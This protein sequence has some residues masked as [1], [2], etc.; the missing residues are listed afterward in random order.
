L[1]EQNSLQ[2]ALDG[3]GSFL[4]FVEVADRYGSTAAGNL[5]CFY[6]GVS[7]LH[8][9]QYE[10]AITYLKKYSGKGVFGQALALGNIGDAY[11]ELGNLDEALTYYKKAAKAS[12][13]SMTAPRFLAK[14]ALIL[15]QQSNYDEAIRLYEQIQ[16]EYANSS[17][18]SD[19]EK[20]IARAKALINQK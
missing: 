13:N 1:F 18:S 10:E 12:D 7:Y 6:A 11:T 16:R 15:E 14:A 9:E 2:P 4:G 19:A 8:L 5:A 20:H 3:D 17:E